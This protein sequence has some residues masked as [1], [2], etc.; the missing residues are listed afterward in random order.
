MYPVL[1]RLRRPI[2]PRRESPP[3]CRIPSP[4]LLPSLFLRKTD[5]GSPA[6]IPMLAL[7]LFL[8][9]LSSRCFYLASCCR[10]RPLLSRVCTLR[11]DVVTRTRHATGLPI[12]HDLKHMK[13]GLLSMVKNDEAKNDSRCRTAVCLVLVCF[14]V[15]FCTN[16]MFSNSRC[17]GLSAVCPF[18]SRRVFMY[19]GCRL[20]SGILRHTVRFFFSIRRA[21]RAAAGYANLSRSKN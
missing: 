11:V 15:F 17:L 19:G 3:E 13:E 21:Q 14:R 18:V 1:C 6:P 10:R 7:L 8:T 12:A 20:V 9:L 5:C 4:E 16:L 2:K